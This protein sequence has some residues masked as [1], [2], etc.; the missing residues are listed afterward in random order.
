MSNHIYFFLFLFPRCSYLHTFSPFYRYSFSSYLTFW[1]T[2]ETSNNTTFIATSWR[3][4]AFKGKVINFLSKLVLICLIELIILVLVNF[5]V[6]FQDISKFLKI[7]IIYINYKILYQINLFYC[8]SK[9]SFKI[10]DYFTIFF[11][12]SLR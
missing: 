4:W 1:L 3:E 5:K 10:T 2:L 8:S 9:N 6:P 12:T 11:V 7:I